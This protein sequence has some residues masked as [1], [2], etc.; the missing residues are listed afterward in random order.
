VDPTTEPTV[1]PTTSA[2][3]TTPTAEPDPDDQPVF[4]K[5]CDDFPDRAAAQDALA[6]GQ[7]DP[8]R[9]DRDGDG[10][11]CE[12][13]FDR[14]GRNNWSRFA[15]WWG[16]R[17]DRD[18]DG[19]WYWDGRVGRDGSDGD[20]GQDGQDGQDGKDGEDGVTRTVYVD[21]YVDGYLDNGGNRSQVNAG[22]QVAIYPAGG[23]DT[24]RA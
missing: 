8:L 18:W 5:D 23:V 19:R 1:D 22:G 15:W 12:R 9:L 14:P 10:A 4:D 6:N 13:H 17:G 20:D 3:T 2:P 16:W 24:G 21:R 7:G 11:A